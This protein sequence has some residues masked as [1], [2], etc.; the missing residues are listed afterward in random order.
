M[1][2]FPSSTKCVCSCVLARMPS[3]FAGVYFLSNI[4]FVTK[5]LSSV[6]MWSE[7]VLNVKLKLGSVW[8][9][10]VCMYCT[11]LVCNHGWMQ[12]RMDG[13]MD[14]GGQL[15][16]SPCRSSLFVCSQYCIR[17]LPGQGTH[18]PDDR[19]VC[20]LVCLS[21]ASKFSRYGCWRYNKIY[22]FMLAPTRV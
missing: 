15:E 4:T 1:T 7:H 12:C 16:G 10:A 6:K 17:H 13:W 2:W 14:D 19:T 8:E 22:Y 21:D 5:S 18:S 3:Y 20:C 9:A 11:R